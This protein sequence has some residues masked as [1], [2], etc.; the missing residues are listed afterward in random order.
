MVCRDFTP[1]PETIRIEVSSEYKSMLCFCQI[2]FDIEGHRER[3]RSRST[4]RPRRRDRSD[5]R[6]RNR[7]R[8]ASRPRHRDRR[9]RERD[10]DRMGRPPSNDPPPEPQRSNNGWGAPTTNTANQG[11]WGVT[12]SQD[13]QQARP[14][15]GWGKEV[16]SNVPY[17]RSPWEPVG[18]IPPK[19][20][21]ASGWGA[22]SSAQDGNRII[23]VFDLNQL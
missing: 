22:T 3:R 18:A 23:N 14:S 7:D 5:D 4:S 1:T 8:Q 6:D 15:D 11:G 20:S 17:R 10:G 13:G 2:V 9:S 19:D 16:E 21:Q 12:S